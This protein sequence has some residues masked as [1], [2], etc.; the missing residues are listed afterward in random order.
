MAE[1][2]NKKE[3]ELLEKMIQDTKKIFEEGSK[4]LAT[5]LIEGERFRKEIEERMKRNGRM[6]NG[7]IV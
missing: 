2:T 5:S 4:G 3:K 7:R 6:T 1:Q